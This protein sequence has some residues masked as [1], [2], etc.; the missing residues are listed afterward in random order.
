MFAY[1]AVLLCQGQ[2][3][4]NPS[5]E[6]ETTGELDPLGWNAC[7]A[8]TTLDV[9]PNIWEIYTPPSDGNTYLGMTAR[10]AMMMQPKNEAAQSRLLQP[11][12]AGECYHF[13][14]DIAQGIA[15]DGLY[16]YQ[17]PLIVYIWGGNFSCSKS[18][19]LAESPIIDHTNWKRYNFLLEP[20][21]NYDYLIMETQ[22]KDNQTGYILIDNMSLVN[23]LHESVTIKSD[24]TIKPD[25]FI[26]LKASEGIWYN[27][28]PKFGLSC[29]D[30]SSP[31]VN[32]E[33]SK[34]FICTVKDTIGCPF[35][36]VFNLTV[37]V[38][39]PNVFTPNGDHVNDVFRIDG[40]KSGSR[41]I[42]YDRNRQVVYKNND[43]DNSWGG[44]DV[45][46]N[47]LTE[48]AYWYYLDIPGENEPYTGYVYIK[49]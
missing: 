30:C 29:Y 17:D 25:D 9:Q 47:V 12:L 39:I 2:Y 45:H 42:I 6:S 35:Q 36:E 37:N 49:R 14:L 38:F 44:E 27:W 26:Q 15:V 10:G 8:N 28:E 7:L 43:Y 23:S 33:S 48:E 11:L 34:V 46:G 16:T 5:F 40:L 3:L 4:S 13:E 31:V 1:T 32:I 22:V 18:E 21:E 24:T 19:K 41:L 20:T